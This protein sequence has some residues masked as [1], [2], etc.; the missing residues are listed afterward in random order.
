MDPLYFRLLN[1]QCYAWLL[2]RSPL[3]KSIGFQNLLCSHYLKW[4]F[5]TKKYPVQV[6]LT[7]FLSRYLLPLNRKYVGKNRLK[8][9]P[10]LFLSIQKPG[11]KKISGGRSKKSFL[12]SPSNMVKN[13]YIFESMHVQPCIWVC[14]LLADLQVTLEQEEQFTFS[15]RQQIHS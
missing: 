7:F 12:H 8:L 5:Q 3:R 4:K 15:K 6:F 13:S 2:P 14:F 11:K 1:N 10:I 9:W